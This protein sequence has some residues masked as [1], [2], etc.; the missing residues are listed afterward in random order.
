LAT[1]PSSPALDRPLVHLQ[2][3]RHKRAR[4]G[5]PW[6]Y[7]NEIVMDAAAKALSRGAL[8][9]LTASNG[10]P[11]GV[12]MFN[13]HTLIA[14]RLLD[15]DGAAAIDAAFIGR[16]LAAA[17]T[18]RERLYPGGFYR[19]IHAEADG[20]PGLIV[21]RYGSTVVVQANTAGMDRLLPDILTALDTELAPETVVLR[22]DS[23]ARQLEGLSAD[24][25]IAK[26]ELTGPVEIIEN[27]ARFLV[28]LH[29]GQKTGWFFDQRDNRAAV[30]RLAGGGRVLDLYT[31]GGGF[32][33][34][35]AQ[36]GAT[37]VTAVDRS[38]PALELASES[39]RRNGVDQRCRFVRA[40]A[41]EELERLAADGARFDVVVADPPAFVKSR[42]DLA[43]GSRGYRKLARLSA[44]VV[45]P[46]GLL[47]IASCSHNVERAL[48]DEEVRRGLGDARRSGR[49]LLSSGAA[50]DHPVHPA[51]PESV[52]LKASLIQLD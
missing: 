13:P 30:A 25:K 4:S 15:R 10:E 43:A 45:A 50:A 23:S 35:A 32:T 47:F 39:A 2:P 27:G 26:G 42:K 46:G 36:A 28:D 33:V 49:I 3:G 51:L 21:D 22:N 19:L 6:V 48:F 11:L 34:T 37:E 8:V 29:G 17:R 52:Y 12:A 9:R 16:K 44:A 38:A 20:L 31:Y 14:A 24:V 40:E 41:F 18:L 1:K 5:H 7:S